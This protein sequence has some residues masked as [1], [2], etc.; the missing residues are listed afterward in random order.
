MENSLFEHS[1]GNQFKLIKENNLSEKSNLV[2]QRWIKEKGIRGAAVK[3]VDNVIGR[4]LGGLT[5]ADLP[6][7]ST[8]A[9]GLDEIEPHLESGD[10][11][12]AL[13][14]AVETAKEMIE[15][16]GGEGII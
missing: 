10:Y 7:T 1:G 8:F 3:M 16:E 9:N 2:V 4:Y 6:D 15:Q 12:T 13:R 5:S 11:R 14:I